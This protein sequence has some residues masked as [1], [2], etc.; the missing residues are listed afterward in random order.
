[1]AQCSVVDAASRVA[2]IYNLGI[3][4]QAEAVGKAMTGAQAAAAG[5]DGPL[6]QQVKAFI[7]GR[8]AAGAWA[9]GDIVPSENQLTRDLGVSRMTAH[10]ALRE[11][12]GEGVLRRVQG[13]GTFVA[14]PKPQSELVEIR[15]I[16]DEIAGR[17]HAHSARVHL[18]RRERA[19][20]RIAA[21]LEKRLGAGVFH[22]VLVHHEDGVPVQVEDRH[23]NP[24]FAPG[25]LD[26]DF[27]RQTPYTYLTAL[28][29][30][31]A[32]EHIIEAVRPHALV[33]RLLAIPADEPCLL[34]TRRTWSNGR[35]V[36]QARLTHPGSRYRLGSR[37]E[38]G[39]H[40]PHPSTGSG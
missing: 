7:L 18:L 32:A 25:Y 9:E 4:P 12:T 20:K 24:D 27:T 23:V 36:S 3:Q 8:I 19:D 31:D 1:M 6:Y 22:S 28:G 38:H 26:Q 13:V 35:V 16:A 40:R 5:A 37:V 21:A 33:R 30:L 11:L 14:V 2:C 29:P 39:R 10:R 15:N 34:L 17:G